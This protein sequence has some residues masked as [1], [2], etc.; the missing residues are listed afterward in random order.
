MKIC[1]LTFGTRG[2]VQPYVAL[3]LGL[4]SAGHDVTVSTLLEFKSLVV[5]YGLQHDALRGDFLKAA[6]AADG[7]SAVEGR[8]NP[9]KLIRQYVAMAR[10]T[11]A[12]EWLSLLM[13]VQV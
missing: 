11:L 13:C 12:D 8:G 6:Q 1:I 7:R 2:D 5:Y 4:Q 3:G 9:L 10:E